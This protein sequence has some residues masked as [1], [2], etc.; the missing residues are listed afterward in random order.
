[1][2]FGASWCPPCKA[3]A[4]IFDK[5][6]VIDE[7]HDAIF[8]SVDVENVGLQAQKYQIRSMPTFLFLRNSKILDRFSGADAI[9]L[10]E[11]IQKH[12]N[13]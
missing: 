6:S 5:L 7:Y 2:K 13:I 11:Y 12:I 4:P 8:I 1:V 3:I 9:K 10:Q